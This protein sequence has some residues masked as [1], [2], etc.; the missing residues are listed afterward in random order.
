VALAV[1]Q[2]TF[3]VVKVVPAFAESQ[4]CVVGVAQTCK[5]VVGATPPH[6][7][8]SNLQ[9]FALHDVA[10]TADVLQYKTS[11]PVKGH[12]SL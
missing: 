3:I 8:T 10:V 12:L 7:V 5:F 9:Q 4:K 11:Y 2:L 1:Q 6:F